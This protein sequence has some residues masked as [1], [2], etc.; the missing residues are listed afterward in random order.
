[1]INTGGAYKDGPAHVLCHNWT[2]QKILEGS[3]WTSQ[4]KT[5]QTR[6]NW[7]SHLYF[8]PVL[9]CVGPCN[10]KVYGIKRLL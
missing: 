8:W 6:Q 4:T 5:K 1:M 9:I 7:T 3:D 10:K 2:G